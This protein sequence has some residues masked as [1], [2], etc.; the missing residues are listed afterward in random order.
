[1]FCESVQNISCLSA[2]TLVV[3]KVYVGKNAQ[4]DRNIRSVQLLL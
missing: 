3:A 1:M 4:C 2:G